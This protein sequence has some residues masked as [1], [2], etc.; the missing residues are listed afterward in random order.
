MKKRIIIGMTGA[1]GAIYGL[2]IL[3]VLKELPEWESHLIISQAGVLNIQHELGLKKQALTDLA[4]KLYSINEI[5]SAIASGAY[6]TEGMLVVPCSMK[7]LASI[8]HGFSDNLIS[9]AAD[10]TLK[11]RRRLVVVPRETPLNLAHIRNMASVTEMGG[12]I[13]PPLPAFYGGNKTVESLV[14]ETVGRLL[15]WF[16]IDAG[17]YEPWEGL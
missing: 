13:Y 14:D 11:E 4:D 17:L 1:T 7:T 12:I 2:R 8:A 16:G 5:G 15:E 10:V 9:R 3:Q 6:K